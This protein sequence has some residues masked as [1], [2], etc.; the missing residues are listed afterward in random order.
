MQTSARFC[1]VFALGLP[2][3]LCPQNCFALFV[4]RVT[5]VAYLI[6]CI[7]TKLLL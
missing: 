4:G 6:I 5:Q 2:P 7:P 3:F 1:E